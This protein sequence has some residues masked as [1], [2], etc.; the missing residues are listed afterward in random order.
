MFAQAVDT[1]GIIDQSGDVIDREQIRMARAGL[2]WTAEHL[3]QQAGLS[4]ATVR[5][6]ESAQVSPGNLYVLQHAFEAAGV[7]FLDED[8]AT[9]GGGRGVRLPRKGQYRRLS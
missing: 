1:K 4:I 5:R 2:G 9:P 7:V 6:A 8:Q 3:A